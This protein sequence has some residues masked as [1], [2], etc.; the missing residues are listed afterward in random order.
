MRQRAVRDIVNLFGRPGA[1]HW[2]SEE[3]GDQP[4]STARDFG[5]V[6]FDVK[7]LEVRIRELN[8]SAA[9]IATS[10]ASKGR[11]QC[12]DSTGCDF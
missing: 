5:A 10:S 3:F 2:V 1:N 9:L 8:L 7:L 11:I 12:W 6:K 4:G